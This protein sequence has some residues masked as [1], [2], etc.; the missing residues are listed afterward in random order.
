MAY[1][2]DSFVADEQPTTAKWNKLWS[3]DASFNDGSGFANGAIGSVHAALAD[4]IQVKAGY[5][6]FNAV[7]TGTT[8]LPMDD[9]VPQNTEGTEF[10][11]IS[12]TP[13]SSTNIL[14]IESQFFGSVSVAADVSLA[15]FQDSTASALSAGSFYQGISGGRVL[16]NHRHIMVAGTTSSTTFKIRAG[17]EVA[18]TLTFNGVSSARRFGD[19]PK[20]HMLIREYKAS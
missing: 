14:V 16:I 2:A 17:M 1:S 8:I 12:Y 10:M 11:T 3:N 9:T 13:K 5:A 20:S 4:G 19:I 18:G 15:L 6:A 7:G